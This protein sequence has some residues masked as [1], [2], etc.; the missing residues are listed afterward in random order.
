MDQEDETV[1]S[2]IIIDDDLGYAESLAD[3]L[4]PKGYTVFYV[5]TPER[6]LAVLRDPRDGG[7]PPPVALIDVRLGGNESGVDLIPHLR[8]E[9][10]ELTCVLM[11]TGIDSETAIAALRRRAY[12]YFDKAWAPVALFAVLDRCFDRVAL[13][14]DRAFE[15]LLSGREPRH[16]AVAHR[17]H[18]G[19]AVRRELMKT[20]AAAATSTASPASPQN[21]AA[22]A[23]A[24]PGIS[25]VQTPGPARP[26][27][28]V[29]GVIPP[30]SAPLAPSA[31]P[32]GSVK[33]KL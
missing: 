33:P 25:P 6:A 8:A 26:E 21:P 27:D 23:L 14:R 9:Q 10:P 22:A 16:E 30:A 24:T 19:A 12:D 28:A 1:R 13:Q 20:K 18:F 7:T 11:T 15:R 32:A 2:V 5:D 31:T 17:L 3:L 4:Q 29:A